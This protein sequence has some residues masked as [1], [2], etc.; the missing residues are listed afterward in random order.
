MACVSSCLG[1]AGMD[2]L[3]WTILSGENGNSQARTLMREPVR[4]LLAWGVLLA[5][6]LPMVI[7]VVLGLGALLFSLGD[8]AGAAAC[9]RIALVIGVA[10]F[11]SLAATAT[12]SGIMTLEGSA[13]RPDRP[14]RPVR[15]VRPED[16]PLEQ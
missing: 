16:P 11:L 6:L 5:V 4:R 13:G 15:P 14:V 8:K 9:G 1:T 10:W 3:E 12:A 2:D 7:A